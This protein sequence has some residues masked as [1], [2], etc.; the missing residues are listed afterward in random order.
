MSC[1]VHFNTDVRS[2]IVAVCGCGYTGKPQDNWDGFVTGYE[3]PKCGEEAKVDMVLDVGTAYRIVTK[4]WPDGNT[5]DKTIKTNIM[6]LRMS[7]DPRNMSEWVAKKGASSILWEVLRALEPDMPKKP[8]MKDFVGQRVSDMKSYIDRAT[9]EAKSLAKIV[10]KKKAVDF[11]VS[12]M[13]D[14]QNGKAAFFKA[15]RVYKAFWRSAFRKEYS[16]MDLFKGKVHEVFERNNP[17]GDDAKAQTRAILDA[18]AQT[19]AILDAKAQ[20]RAILMAMGIDLKKVKMSSKFKFVSMASKLADK[21]A[22]AAFKV[23]KGRMARTTVNALL[24]HIGE[25]EKF[26]ELRDFLLGVYQE[27]GNVYIRTSVIKSMKIGDV[28]VPGMRV[29]RM[30]SYKPFEKSTWKHKAFMEEHPEFFANPEF[31]MERG[32]L[33]TEK[34]GS[35]W[36]YDSVWKGMIQV[37]GPW[38]DTCLMTKAKMKGGWKMIDLVPYNENVGN[39]EDE[40]EDE[41]S[42]EPVSTEEDTDIG[43]DIDEEDSAAA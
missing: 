16:I 13:E 17:Y 25:N 41:D 40:D 3:C 20:T 23:I 12:A 19:R 26:A 34:D 22:E 32:T 6:E 9:S 39:D 5:Y 33:T 24:E 31:S 10:G 36:I 42:W 21:R 11:A 35:N 18:K 28:F 15:L 43:S 27:F 30:A 1:D 38:Y 14:A 29:I 7:D 4:K 8:K 37:S 2:G